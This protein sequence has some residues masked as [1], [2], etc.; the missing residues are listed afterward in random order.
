[1]DK[2][3]RAAAKEAGKYA[4]ARFS[5]H[6]LVRHKSASPWSIVTDVDIATE[7]LLI[8]RIRTA[9]PGHGVI[10]EESGRVRANAEYV[11]VIDPI[12]GTLNFASGIPLFG[13]MLA[14]VHKGEVVL[15]AIY[16]PLL[17]E[18]Y[19]AKKGK[20][21]H[22]NGTRIHAS[23]TKKFTNSRG[24]G[25]SSIRMRT[26]PFIVRIFK[27]IGQE[28]VV[29]NSFGA[30]SV[31]ACFVACGRRDW[32]MAPHGELHDFAPTYL[33]LKEAG[34]SVS[35]AAGKEWKFGAQGIVAANPVLHRQLLKLRAKA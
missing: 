29:F 10:A 11:W 1:M 3:I 26:A 24:V 21:A 4:M 17:D 27:A 28:H 19:V 18:L 13:T 7:Q 30:I 35:D 9:Y 5:K 16:L 2:F 12:D 25:F 20:G 8:K 23:R 22:L 32:I 31:N 6:R 33:L 15:S 34:C 14:L